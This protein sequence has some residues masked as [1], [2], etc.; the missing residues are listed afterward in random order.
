[1]AGATIVAGHL[2][3]SLGTALLQAA[4]DA[5]SIGMAD[6]LRVSAGAMVAA[7]LLIGTFL[8]AGTKAVRRRRSTREDAPA[9]LVM[10]PSRLA[11]AEEAADTSRHPP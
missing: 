1:M 2:P 3:A 5:Y 11:L 9:V 7:A 8:P 6:V 10:D 4:Q